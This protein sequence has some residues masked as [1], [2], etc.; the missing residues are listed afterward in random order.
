MC[1]PRLI[2][3]VAVK[4]ELTAA[5]RRAGEYLPFSPA[6]DAAMGR[7]EDLERELWRLEEPGR[8]VRANASA[9]T[10]LALGRP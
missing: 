1:P 9:V 3:R 2:D 6:W 10:A 8:G 5:R 4:A 7:V